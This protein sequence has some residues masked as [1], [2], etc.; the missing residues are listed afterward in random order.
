MNCQS[1]TTHPHASGF[2]LLLSSCRAKTTKTDDVMIPFKIAAWKERGAW[3]AKP[4]KTIALWFIPNRQPSPWGEDGLW[5]VQQRCLH[6]LHINS[7]SSVGAKTGD[8]L[9][10]EAMN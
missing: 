6:P 1:P 10:Q 4:E 5:L 2:L 7:N 8:S 3:P 9:E